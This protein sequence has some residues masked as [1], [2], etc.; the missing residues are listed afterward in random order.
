MTRCIPKYS[1]LTSTLHVVAVEK[2]LTSMILFE[3]CN[4]INQHTLSGLVT[5]I[6]TSFPFA[7]R[8]YCLTLNR[9]LAI[10]YID[11]SPNKLNSTSDLTLIE[12]HDKMVY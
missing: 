8:K 4:F 11:I 3:H 9:S 12:D 5:F 2:Q 7:C 10:L 6:P 1:N